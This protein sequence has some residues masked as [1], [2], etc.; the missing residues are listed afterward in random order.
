MRGRSDDG[1]SDDAQALG[2]NGQREGYE[3]RGRMGGTGEKVGEVFAV[4]GGVSFRSGNSHYRVGGLVAAHALA[5]CC[6]FCL[7]LVAI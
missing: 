6:G 4:S 1:E 7:F 5:W 3:R 2:S